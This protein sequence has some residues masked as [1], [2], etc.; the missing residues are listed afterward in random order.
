MYKKIEQEFK[1]YLIVPSPASGFKKRRKGWDQIEQICY[2]LKRDFHLPVLKV[3]GKKKSIGQKVL[4]L[5]ER[6]KNLE[7]KIRF[8]IRYSSMI[9]GKKIL[10]ID[11]VFTTGATLNECSFQLCKA[12]AE[13]V[14][15]LTIASD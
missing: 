5:E 7:G 14:S 11:D 8:K 12:G 9:K 6:K 1:D 15:A 3:L 13:T 2:H 10:I 4:S